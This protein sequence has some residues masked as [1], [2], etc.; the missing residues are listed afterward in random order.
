MPFIDT[1]ALS[2]TFSRSYAEE[3]DLAFS[4]IDCVLNDEK[5]S[6]ASTELTTGRRVH[7]V[8]RELGAMRSADLKT[9]L[10]A[11]GYATRVW[12][13]NVGAA[14][15]FARRLHHSLGGNQLVIT[16]A[17]FTA[18]GWSQPEY[19]G[20]W[21]T[22]IRTRINAVYF[23][24]EWEYSNGCTFEFLVA[25][26]A[27][28]PTFDAHGT[29]IDLETAIARI[30]TA[31]GVVRGDRLEYETLADNLR[32]LQERTTADRASGSR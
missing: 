31:V 16:P 3:S 8:Q 32:R 23:N 5:A 29:P 10:G 4:A 12:N 21:E 2:S 25:V 6:Y 26:D 11:Q 9:R 15:A 1:R 24:D 13:P 27:G 18:P 7:A 28:L 30:E 14:M 20:F 22:L 17:P 19:L